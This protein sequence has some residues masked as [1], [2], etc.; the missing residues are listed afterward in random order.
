[1]KKQRIA[2]LLVL[3]LLL[4]LFSACRKAPEAPPLKAYTPT[5][6]I[7][8]MPQIGDGVNYQAKL[9]EALASTETVPA[10]DLQYT[11]SDGAVTV[12][13]Y[14]GQSTAI[15]IPEA[16]EGAPVTAIAAGAFAE[17]A[18]LTVIKLPP[19]ILSIGFGALEDCTALIALETPTF[20]GNDNTAGHLGYLFGAETYSDNPL[21]IPATLQYL[22]LT[23]MSELLDHALLDCND[24]VAVQL[25]ATLTKIGSYALYQCEK[26]KY[27][28]LEKVKEFGDHAL[29]GCSALQALDFSSAEHIGIGTLEGCGALQELALPFVGESVEKNTYLG[30][31]FG[32]EVPDFTA[33]Y[34]PASLVSLKLTDACTSLG[35]YAFFECKTLLS[36]TLSENIQS[37]GVRAFA[38]CVYLTELHFSDALSKIRENAF[39]G[40]TG[41]QRVTLGNSLSELGIN[42]FYNCHALAEITLPDSLKEIPASCFVNCVSLEKVN[43]DDRTVGKDAF[44]NCPKLATES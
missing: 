31:I 29:E 14:T 18:A 5:Q 27:V 22:S 17:K 36:V 44:R 11:V 32:A 15:A 8:S 7:P 35:D 1:M 37:V 12:T 41:L 19:S 2:A 3:C 20:G 43:I 21:K 28:N 33:G 25:P 30:Y 4:C 9:Q 13:G 40:C 38:G 42:A 26:L 16:V 10:A 24:L 34:V 39:F 23:A 6:N